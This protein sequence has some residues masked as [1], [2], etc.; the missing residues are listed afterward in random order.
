M[1]KIV[2]NGSFGKFGSMHSMLYAPDFLIQ[3]TLTGQLCLLMLIERL[4]LRGIS[5][6]S[7][8]TDG[9]VVHCPRDREQEVQAIFAQWREDTNFETEETTYAGIYSRDVNNY[10]AIKTNGG[11]KSKGAYSETG[12]HKNP[13]NEICANAVRAFLLQGTPIAATVR[14]SADIR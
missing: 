1:L 4:E 5:V 10:I 3:T 12:L 9:I 2:V 8:N 13:T 11:V 6:L 14:G 7:A